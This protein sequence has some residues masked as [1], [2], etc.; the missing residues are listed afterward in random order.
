[1]QLCKKQ[2]ASCQLFAPFL[3]SASNFEHFEKKMTL[4]AFVF[5]KLQTGED[6]VKPMCEKHHFRTPFNSRHAK[7][8]QTFV[9]SGWH[10]FYHIFSWHWEK[11]TW[12]MSLFVVC[13]ILGHFV[14]TLTADD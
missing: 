3:K 11:L 10:Q 9:K 4:T 13:E 7:G 6:L 8:S 1:M 12:K 5:A 2:K 14:N